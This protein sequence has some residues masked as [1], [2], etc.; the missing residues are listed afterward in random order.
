MFQTQYVFIHTA[1]S[2][3]ITCG[4]T[5]IAAANIRI[6]IGRLGRMVASSSVTGFQNQ[7]EVELHLMI[8]DETVHGALCMR[9]NQSLHLYFLNADT[10]T[11]V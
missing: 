11:Q 3:L 8:L 1:L 4:D 7:F 9:C 5:E 2:E 6:A 10:V